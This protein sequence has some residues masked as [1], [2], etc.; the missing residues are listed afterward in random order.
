M[1]RIGSVSE[2]VSIRVIRG[3]A[4]LR[5]SPRDPWPLLASAEPDVLWLLLALS[6]RELHRRRQQTLQQRRIEPLARL[7]IIDR[8]EQVVAGGQAAESE[9]AVGRG[10]TA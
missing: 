9:R 10:R 1:T 2:S 3:Q 6:D 7:H 5:V 8:R 4:G